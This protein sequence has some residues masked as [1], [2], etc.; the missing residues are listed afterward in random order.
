MSSLL[1]KYT[2]VI[3]VCFLTIGVYGQ[4]KVT[5]TPNFPKKTTFPDAISKK[6]EK[7]SKMPIHNPDYALDE[8]IK[9]A[10]IDDTPKVMPIFKPYL[11]LE[12]KPA[13]KVSFADLKTVKEIKKNVKKGN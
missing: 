9:H 7:D 3:L 11:S 2:F 12:L 8:Q 10:L 5:K 6:A 1:H 4:E 13:P